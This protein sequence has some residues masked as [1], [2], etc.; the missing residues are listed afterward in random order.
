[1]KA[2]QLPPLSAGGYSVDRKEYCNDDLDRHVPM[3]PSR[4]LIQ[5]IP[6]NPAGR[7]GRKGFAMK[8]RRS[9]EQIVGLLRQADVALGKGEKVPE[10]FKQLGIS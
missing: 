5:G 4:K 8:K 1:M 9:A 2:A 7:F 6:E 10:V 3:S